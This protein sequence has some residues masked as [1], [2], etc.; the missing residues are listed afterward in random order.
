MPKVCAVDED[1]CL[2]LDSILC[3]FH[4]GIKEEQSWALIHQSVACLKEDLIR[5]SDHLFIKL[6]HLYIKNNGTIHHKS[7][8]K[9]SSTVH[10][11]SIQSVVSSLG[12]TI[13]K[14]L[15]Y[16]TEEDE[17]III[18]SS[19]EKTFEQMIN[20]DTGDDDSVDEIEVDFDWQH[21]LDDLLN[22]CRDRMIDDTDIEEHYRH[23]C[24]ALVAEAIEMSTFLSQISI[25]TKE[26]KK[27]NRIDNEEVDK[28]HVEVWA[29]L[30]MKVMRQL[31][32]GVS[33]NHINRQES[34]HRQQKEYELTPFEMLLDDINSKR[35]SLKKVVNL[36][37]RVEKDARTLIMDFIRSRPPLKPVADRVLSP[38]PQRPPTLH[39][40]LMDDIKQTPHLRPSPQPFERKY[41]S[42]HLPRGQRYSLLNDPKTT[43]EDS[44]TNVFQRFS[45][46]NLSLR[47]GAINRITTL[48]PE[49]IPIAQEITESYAKAAARRPSLWDKI[50]RTIWQ[51]VDNH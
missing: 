16:G 43:S 5:N 7:W 30:W 11:V 50:C 12:T 46:R 17:E 19:L 20:Y 40:K 34:L 28:I 33:L 47:S 51:K 41:D 44:T 15:D 25:G 31:R 4:C 9:T 35:Y 24:R 49:S 14:A 23:V 22:K 39:E 6:N 27:I 13:Y 38:L 45:F 29:H 3:A 10:S 36:P 1:N 21:F 8:L 32:V 48:K 2:T 26:L 37:K 42:L 18:S